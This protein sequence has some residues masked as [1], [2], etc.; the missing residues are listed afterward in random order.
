MAVKEV[1]GEPRRQTRTAT[2]DDERNRS[3]RDGQVNALRGEISQKADYAA[4]SAAFDELVAILEGL[5]VTYV[6]PFSID[7][8]AGGGFQ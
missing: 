6:N 5:G 3:E 4:L 7:P 8:N 2:I 1:K